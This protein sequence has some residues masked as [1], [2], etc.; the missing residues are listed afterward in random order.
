[1]A[2]QPVEERRRPRSRNS[3]GSRARAAPAI[4]ASPC[5]ICT[6]LPRSLRSSL[7]SWLPGTHSAVPRR[8]HAPSPA[9]ARPAMRGPRSTRSPTK[10]A[11]RP[12]GCGVRGAAVS[13]AVGRRDRVA[14]LLEQRHQL[15]EAA[16]DVADDVE[17]A[18]L[19]ACGR[20]RAAARSI[21]GRVDLLGRLQ[22][23]DVAEALALQAAQRAAQLLALVADDVRA[24]VA[25]GPRRGC[26]PGR[27]ARAGRARS[28]PAARGTRAPAR[29][30]ACAPP[31]GRWSRRPRSAARAPAACRR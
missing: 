3:G 8:D 2:D 16:V 22:D 21:V 31:A 26:A 4:S 18:V 12:S 10:T 28:P 6:S 1:M 30:A 7:M 25:V 24:E 11:L 27:A 14:E 5:V 15:V 17:R 29:P 19:V 23:E 13:V 9:A 20:S